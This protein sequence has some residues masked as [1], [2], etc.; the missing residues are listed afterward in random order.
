MTHDGRS[1]Q[2]LKIRPAL[3]RSYPCLTAEILKEMAAKQAIAG[4]PADT[5]DSSGP[6]TQCERLLLH[7][8]TFLIG[9]WNL[10]IIDLATSPDLIWFWPLVASWA[11]ILALHLGY[12]LVLSHRGRRRDATPLLMG[13]EPTMGGTR[14]A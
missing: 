4:F 1:N 8:F 2:A 14:H 6:F 3:H 11:A 12:V 9:S 5:G 13:G 7:L 10:A